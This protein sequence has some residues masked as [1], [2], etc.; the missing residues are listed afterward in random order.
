MVPKWDG[1]PEK[2]EDSSHALKM[3]TFADTR[4]CAVLLLLTRAVSYQVILSTVA[5]WFDN[6]CTAMR[7]LVPCVP[8]PSL[9]CK[10][11]WDAFW[12]CHWS[13]CLS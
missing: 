1:H 7:I 2:N 11:I 3:L 9:L 13:R 5:G 10:E 6:S 4:C 12:W 8:V